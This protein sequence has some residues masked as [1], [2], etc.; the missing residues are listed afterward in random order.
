[1]H[2]Q[3]IKDVQIDRILNHPAYRGRDDGEQH[4]HLIQLKGLT[5]EELKRRF[6]KLHAS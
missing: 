6:A 5:L 3:P 2:D 4:E 1:M